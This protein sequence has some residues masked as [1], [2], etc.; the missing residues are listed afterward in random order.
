MASFEK[1]AIA[2]RDS[3]IIL[4]GYFTIVTGDPLQKTFLSI[5][6][7]EAHNPKTTSVFP[8]FITGK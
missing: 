4:A 8:F 1:I 6:D 2:K 7:F 3:F 5:L